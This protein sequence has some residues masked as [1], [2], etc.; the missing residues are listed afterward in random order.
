MKLEQ[1]VVN[2]VVHQITHRKIEQ[3]DLPKEMII[4][5]YQI[6][7]DEAYHAY[8]CADFKSQLETATGCRA[9]NISPVSLRKFLEIKYSYSRQIQQLL[10]VFFVFVSETSISGILTKI[11]IDKRVKASVRQL[12][13]DHAID[14]ARHHLYFSR[15][16]PYLWSALNKQ[17]RILIG[18]LLPRFIWI[19]LEP[20]QSALQTILAD[21][22]LKPQ[23]IELVI[24]ESY[25][26]LQVTTGIRKAARATLA[27][28]E[29]NQVFE[30][31]KILEA[32]QSSGLWQ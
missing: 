29:K 22:N 4:E 7:V 8:F 32:F 19:F 3:I 14:E 26:L 20:D 10:E 13:T 12:I 28:L 18:T 6:Y 25:P 24:K 21:F 9:V 17:E 30:E 5:A 27:I 16:F 11:P 15:L 2:S 1:E 31:P 23:E